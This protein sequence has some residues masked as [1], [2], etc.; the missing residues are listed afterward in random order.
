MG[1]KIIFIIIIIVGLG[2]GLYLYSSGVLVKGVSG[3][4][5]LFPSPS[6]GGL[7]G[8]SSSTTASK[9]S[10][11]TSSFWSFLLPGTGAPVGPAAPS[12]GTTFEPPSS[13][14]GSNGASVINPA[15]I[16]AGY[17]AAQLSP[18]YHEVLFGT[19][20]AGTSYY[21]G[22]IT[23]NTYFNNT[24]ATG[25]IDVTGWE[26][27]S[28]DSGEY[29]P[30]AIAVYDPTGLTAPSDIRVKNGDTV[31]LYSSSAPFN[32]RLNE[33]IGY[34]ANVA[35]FEPPLPLTCPYLDQS[36]IQNFTGQCQNY[37][38]SIGQCQ[39]PNMSS[40]QIPRTDYACQDYLENN[41]TYKSCFNEHDT[42]PNFLSNQV[43]VWT[44]SNILDPYHD[45]V[46]LL[47]R[48]GLLVDEYTY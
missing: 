46:L 2:L 9:S 38:D 21:Y 25:T 41:F 6:S 31:Y 16:P 5:S 18:Y 8:S 3:F 35:N 32:L 7:F 14:A 48:N 30:Q 45:T 26:I 22:T 34:V 40:P 15:D 17:T 28:K 37:I 13:A 47:D 24:N 19:V 33:C 29:I 23:L 11:S 42:D 27:K 4:N 1:G 36:Q 44:G 12:G 39:A 10:S 43:W 20:S